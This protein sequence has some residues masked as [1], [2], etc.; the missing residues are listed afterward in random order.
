MKKYEIE[1]WIQGFEQN[2]IY[3]TDERSFADAFNAAMVTVFA[4]KKYKRKCR[5]IRIQLMDYPTQK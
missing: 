2:L 3:Q 4:H 1:I 5:V